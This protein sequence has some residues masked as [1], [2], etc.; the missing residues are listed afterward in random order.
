M[1]LA[2]INTVMCIIIIQ[3]LHACHDRSPC[4]KESVC[5]F[6]CVISQRFI[7][8]PW[9]V[10]SNSTSGMSGLYSLNWERF[11]A[12]TPEA[13]ENERGYLQKAGDDTPNIEGTLGRSVCVMTV[14]VANQ[15]TF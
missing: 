9:M 6:G 7:Q 11:R 4:V 2:F 8:G 10:V 3:D 14:S 5:L 13:E 15:I 1:Q 12:A